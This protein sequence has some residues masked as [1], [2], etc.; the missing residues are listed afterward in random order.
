MLISP[1]KSP[2]FLSSA[3]ERFIKVWK[4]SGNN[5]K[6]ISPCHEL[7]C[8]SPPI[9][10]DCITNGKKHLIIALINDS[11]FLIWQEKFSFK[12]SCGSL[13]PHY[14]IYFPITSRSL[15]LFFDVQ[16]INF[17]QALLVSGLHEKPIYRTVFLDNE[18]KDVILKT[19]T[20]KIHTNIKKKT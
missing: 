3:Q 2:F 7:Q 9:C 8:I 18:K 14:A 11:K 17:K 19:Q 13:P 15:T 1:K 20:S 5:K 6:N 16:I 12:K 10:F 4:R